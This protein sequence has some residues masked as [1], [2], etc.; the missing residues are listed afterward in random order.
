MHVFLLGTKGPHSFIFFNYL[1]KKCGVRK[2]K[3]RV[4]FFDIESEVELSKLVSMEVF[5]GV[6]VFFSGDIY[7]KNLYHKVK[8][9][10]ISSLSSLNSKIVASCL[11]MGLFKP[12]QLFIR[13]TD[14][15]IDRWKK[16]YDEKGRLV[17]DE[18]KYF[19]EDSHYVLKN[20]SNF[21]CLYNPWGEILK[22]ITGR[23]V[24]IHEVLIDGDKFVV[25]GLE[26]FFD[27]KLRYSIG[28]QSCSSGKLR[29]M[30]FSKPKGVKQDINFL[31]S[32]LIY[33]VSA[34]STEKRKGYELVLWAKYPQKRLISYIHYKFMLLILYLC[35]KFKGVSLS[36]TFLNNLPREAYFS[37]LASCHVLYFQDRGGLGA[38]HECMKSGG[39]IILREGSFNHKVISGYS[40]LNVVP[41]CERENS[42]KKSLSLFS[43]LGSF[44]FMRK[45][46]EAAINFFNKNLSRAKA[47]VNS[48]YC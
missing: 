46:S 13:I 33:L 6:E 21:I 38:A 42:I 44:G 30:V 41:F 24:N 43:E 22:K 9:V 14:D 32:F 48:I 35:S 29:F 18:S 23:K 16:I 39:V 19:D 12:E 17:V 31:K 11:R 15:E 45:N 1:V 7:N 47:T 25:G 5:E 10:T 34:K 28:Q 8:T 2:S 27:D 26:S 40:G 37:I 36:F 3:L 4:I 20:T